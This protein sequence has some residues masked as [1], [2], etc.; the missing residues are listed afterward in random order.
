MSTV[1]QTLG[2]NMTE[3]VKTTIELFMDVWTNATRYQHKIDMLLHEAKDAIKA[4]HFPRYGHTVLFSPIEVAEHAAGKYLVIFPIEY[5]RDNDAEYNSYTI[6]LEDCMAGRDAV[7]AFFVE[8]KRKQQ[9]KAD[10]MGL[11][12]LAKEREDRRR[13]YDKLKLEFDPPVEAIIKHGD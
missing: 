3:A 10:A 12:R 11:Q 1:L 5:H 2:V 8:E 13:L 9:E 6:P 4:Y 7:I